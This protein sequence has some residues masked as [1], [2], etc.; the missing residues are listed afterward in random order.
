M[1]QLMSL[2]DVD[3]EPRAH[4]RHSDPHTSHEA[5]K[6]VRGITESQERILEIITYF[7]PLSDETIA[8]HY[9]RMADLN[10]WKLMSPSGL[11]SRRAELV[12]QGKVR[13][14]GRR[15]TTASGRATTIWE[16]AS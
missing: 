7:G 4:A 14:S 3:V 8:V 15:G 13:D 1:S 6:T 9:A 12:A 10:R 5:A 16:V 11:R 2:F